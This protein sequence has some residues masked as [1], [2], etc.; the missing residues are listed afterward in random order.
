MPKI[1]FRESA[2][3]QYAAIEQIDGMMQVMRPSAWW[4]LAACSLLILAGLIWSLLGTIAST[5]EGRGILLHEG[6]KVTQILAPASGKIK[7]IFVS[8]GQRVKAGDL[9]GQM[10]QPVLAQ[11]IK[12]YESELSFLK[13]KLKAGSASAADL[14]LERSILQVQEKLSK[15]KIEFESA[16]K[17]IAGQDGVISNFL[18]FEGMLVEPF[19][20]LFVLQ[21]GGKKLQALIF[22]P[23]GAGKEVHPGQLVEISPESSNS[24]ETGYLLGKVVSVDR[25]PLSPEGMSALVSDTTLIRRWCSELGAPLSARVDLIEDQNSANKYK[26]TSPRGNSLTLSSGTLVKAKALVKVT[27]VIKLLIPAI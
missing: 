25:L 1:E 13:S 22:F 21:T 6:G 19:H 24:E 9:L 26:W 20:P 5:V 27:R 11:D 14:E 16:S 2:I 3:N 7:E 15:A 8:P 17:I 18:S 23:S 4:W 10:D 12:A